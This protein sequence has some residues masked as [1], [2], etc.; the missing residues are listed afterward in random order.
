MSPIIVIGKNIRQGDDEHDRRII[1]NDFH[2]LPTTGHAGI[3][4]T[5]NTIKQRYHWKSLDSDVASFI[6]KC[7]LCQR[8]K[9]YR[10]KQP[11]QLTSTAGQAFE[12][13]FLDT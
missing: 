4:G 9:D 11:M 1:I 8:N 2:I 3:K 6:Q 13:V 7:T 12:K 5:F 10:T